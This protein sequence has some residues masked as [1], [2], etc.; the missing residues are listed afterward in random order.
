MVGTFLG[1]VRYRF[2]SER[3]AAEFLIAAFPLDGSGPL[4]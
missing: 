1:F 2:V 3:S 4:R